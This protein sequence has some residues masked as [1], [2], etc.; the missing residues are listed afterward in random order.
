MVRQ[1]NAG[2]CSNRILPD[3]QRRDSLRSWR[4]TLQRAPVAGYGRAGRKG[5]QAEACATEGVKRV[6]KAKEGD[7]GGFAN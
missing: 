1:G 3:T 2:R 7:G 5:P 4:G 6:W